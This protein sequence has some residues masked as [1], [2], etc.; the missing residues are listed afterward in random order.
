MAGSA[1][2]ASKVA[3]AFPRDP[4]GSCDTCGLHLEVWKQTSVSYRMAGRDEVARGC[5]TERIWRGRSTRARA[6]W[7]SP[8]FI[9][10]EAP[11]AEGACQVARGRARSLGAAEG[12]LTDSQNKEASVWRKA[13]HVEGWREA[14][15]VP[16]SS[17]SKMASSKDPSEQERTG[18]APFRGQSGRV[19]P[20]PPFPLFAP[21]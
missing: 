10:A 6:A 17:L 1:A 7:G 18:Q 4:R 15:K 14:S 20:A 8:G 12:A 16:Q 19:S 5:K 9:S 13:A 11:G 21:C 2:V 3:R